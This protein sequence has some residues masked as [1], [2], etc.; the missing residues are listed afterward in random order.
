MKV[1]VRQAENVI[2]VDLD[3]DLVAGVGDELLSQVMNEL[4]AEDWKKI[5]LNLSK[6]SKI[7]SCGIGEIVAGIKLAARFGSVV[8]LVNVG[9]KVRDVFDLTRILPLLDIHDNEAQA[10]K[11][12]AA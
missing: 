3:A 9:E 5:L 6:V 11:A 4:L 10:L 1:D 12:F 2:I 7:D 8:K